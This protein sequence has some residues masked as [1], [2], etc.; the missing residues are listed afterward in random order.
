MICCDLRKSALLP[1]LA[2]TANK[3]CLLVHKGVDNTTMTFC[4]A[5]VIVCV[6]ESC[7]QYQ[8]KVWF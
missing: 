6:S 7:K 8:T 5:N 4:R 1:S 2:V 3:S